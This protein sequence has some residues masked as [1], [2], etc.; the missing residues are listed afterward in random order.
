[1]YEESIQSLLDIRSE[2][3]AKL[4][5]IDTAIELMRSIDTQHVETSFEETVA[6]TPKRKSKRVKST[7]FESAIDL[8]SISDFNE[9]GGGIRTDV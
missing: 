6:P 7:S 5:S 4:R 8:T 9:S 1:M 3:E 2:L